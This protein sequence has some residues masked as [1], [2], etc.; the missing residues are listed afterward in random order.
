MNIYKFTF[1][2]LQIKQ[3]LSQIAYKGYAQD[4]TYA[5]IPL[6]GRYVP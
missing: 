6:L 3:L 4:I 2:T 1:K 5:P